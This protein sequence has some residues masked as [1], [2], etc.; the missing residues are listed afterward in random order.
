MS[1]FR[2]RTLPHPQHGPLLASALYLLWPIRFRI[3]ALEFTYIFL[4]QFPIGHDVIKCFLLG[5]VI[6]V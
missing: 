1:V 5:K 3:L 2:R 4:E 6:L